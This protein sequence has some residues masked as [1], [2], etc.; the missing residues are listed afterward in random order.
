MLTLFKKFK[1]CKFMMKRNRADSIK[2]E[3]FKL[4]NLGNEKKKELQDSLLAPKSRFQRIRKSFRQLKNKLSRFKK[5]D[6]IFRLGFGIVAFRD[7]M[8][9]MI[10]IFAIFT[11]FLIPQLSIFKKYNNST[12]NNLMLSSLGYSTALCVN[13]PVEL[14]KV[15]AKCK[16]GQIGRILSFGVTNK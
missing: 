2:D 7:I 1:C 16:F 9:S 3:Q 5:Q 15:Q 11:I 10:V 6:P 12:S 4:Q 14:G 13:L 8:K